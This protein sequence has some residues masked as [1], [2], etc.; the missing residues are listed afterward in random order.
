MQFGSD[1]AG[2]EYLRRVE[3]HTAPRILPIPGTLRRSA[4]CVMRAICLFR[5]KW[6][7]SIICLG[8]GGLLAIIGMVVGS[9][10]V[11]P[12]VDRDYEE[13][14]RGTVSDGRAESGPTND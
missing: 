12:S 8:I 14:R 2:N 3:Q 9:E 1:G 6:L 4:V 10:R 11:R 7:A 13:S 5:A